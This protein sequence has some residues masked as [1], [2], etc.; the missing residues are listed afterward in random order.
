MRTA[1]RKHNAVKARFRA[2]AVGAAVVLFFL[3]LGLLA[4]IPSIGRPLHAILLYVGLYMA[5]VP[6]ITISVGLFSEERRN[7]TMELL[8]LAGV[9]PAEL[10]G[11]KLLGGMMVASGNLLA[12]APVLAVP[13][14]TGGISFNLFLATI[15]CFPALLLFVTSV[16]VLASVLCRDDGS[17]FICA[18]VIGAIITLATPV[19]Y[20]MGNMLAGV[21][22]FSAKWLCLSPGYA[23]YLVAYNFAGNQPQIF[24]LGW[25]ATIGW[26]FLCMG[27]GA[28]LL[29]RTWRKELERSVHS[30]WRAKWEA[31]VHGSDE[32]R[33]DLRRRLLA[34]N[35]FQWLVEQDRSP[36]TA[37]WGIVG[38]VSLIWLAG[39]ALW[40]RVWPSP[41][42]YYLTAGILIAGVEMVMAYAAARRIGNDRR[43][44]ALELLLT[45]PLQPE[46]MVD[47]QYQALSKL[48]KPVRLTIFGLCVLMMLAGLLRPGWNTGPLV[49]YFLIWGLLLLWSVRSTKRSVALSMWI[50]ANTG[51][52]AFAIIRFR[53]QNPWYWIGMAFN[54]RNFFRAFGRGG[55]VHFPTGSPGELIFVGLFS[56]V[57]LCVAVATHRSPNKL[58]HRLIVELRSIAREPVPDPHDPRFKKWNFTERLPRSAYEEMAERV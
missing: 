30:G 9:G 58:R 31:L 19:P 24:W 54:L 36:L 29:R 40:P 34:I 48:F 22:P 8:Y 46:E 37:A 47:G 21:P 49:S 16:G 26:S 6:P 52:P 56:L 25:A 12:L 11:G 51:R 10:F 39:W 20:A 50:G 3:L 17:A 7:Q 13:F 27:T 5:I 4:G 57:M 15:A 32:W 35:P 14:L 43:D 28:L 42:N 45:T 2:A 41:A 1:L 23:P 55:G 33:L 18:V 44:G 38:G 53:R